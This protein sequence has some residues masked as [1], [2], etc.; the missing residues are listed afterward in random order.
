MAETLHATFNAAD[1]AAP[2]QVR[3]AYAKLRAFNL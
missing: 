2:A 1:P 3:A